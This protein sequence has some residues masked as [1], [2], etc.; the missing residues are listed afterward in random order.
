MGKS[1]IRKKINAKGARASGG[2]GGGGLTSFNGRTAAAVIPTPGDYL[3]VDLAYA[4]ITTETNA[5]NLIDG[6]LY[7]ITG[8]P[9][10]TSGIQLKN[11]YV[12]AH[13]DDDVAGTPLVVLD[14]M[15][16]ANLSSIG[17]QYQVWMWYNWYLSQIIR[18]WDNSGN[19]VEGNANCDNFLFGTYQN[20]KIGAGFTLDLTV[21]PTTFNNNIGLGSGTLTTKGRAYDN[22]NLDKGYFLVYGNI[23]Q[24]GALV[25]PTITLFKNECTGTLTP[26][27]SG[28]PGEYRLDN[29]YAG[30]GASASDVWLHIGNP[31]VALGADSSIVWN[32]DSR[33]DFF[34]AQ[35]GSG[36]DDIFIDTPFEIRVMIT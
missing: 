31:P 33:I 7:N 22:I 10:F 28:V 32:S 9:A 24:S 16:V 23:T 34:S 4:D 20:N 11:V 30:F 26:S 14:F 25:D 17:A 8:F 36:A 5:G 13:I 3:P 18:I 27:S 12:Y 19:Q 15:S 21:S 2:G 1:V 29:S 35:F 6:Q